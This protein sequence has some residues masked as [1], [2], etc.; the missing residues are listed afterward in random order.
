MGIDMEYLEDEWKIALDED[1]KCMIKYEITSKLRRIK[2]RKQVLWQIEEGKRKWEDVEGIHDE[3]DW[4][5][6]GSNG[7]KSWLD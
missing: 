6:E 7:S 3:G 2:E 4:Q 1:R 5:T